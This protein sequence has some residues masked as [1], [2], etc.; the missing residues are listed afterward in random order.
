MLCS[1]GNIPLYGGILCRRRSRPIHLQRQGLSSL[2][3][4][5]RDGVRDC[6]NLGLQLYPEFDVAGAGES[7]YPSRSVCLVCGVGLHRL[8]ICVLLLTRNKGTEFGEAGYYFLG[9]GTGPC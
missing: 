8:G 3:T 1:F 2:H 5:V 9:E 4:R 6:D 7:F